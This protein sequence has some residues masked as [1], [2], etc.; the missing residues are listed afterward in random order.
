MGV[1]ELVFDQKIPKEIQGA[2]WTGLIH[3]AKNGIAWQIQNFDKENRLKIK[4]LSSSWAITQT[5]STICMNIG[6]KR[7]A[8]MH[9]IVLQYIVKAGDINGYV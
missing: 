3:S 1:D 2:L 4:V 9:R 5:Q 7:S 8:E 6:M